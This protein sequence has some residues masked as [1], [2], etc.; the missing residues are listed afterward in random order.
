MKAYFNNIVC[1]CGTSMSIEKDKVVC[2][3]K[4]CKNSKKIFERPTITL[5]EKRGGK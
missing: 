1:D 5:K 2:K 4:S 3:N